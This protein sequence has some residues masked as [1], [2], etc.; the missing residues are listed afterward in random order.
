[1]IKTPFTRMNHQSWK[2]GNRE[3]K[4][5]EGKKG[6]HVRMS[7]LSDGVF[8]GNSWRYFGE[9]DATRTRRAPGRWTK[10]KAR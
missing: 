8:D 9:S 4:Q 2:S 10:K 7:R 1:M 6:K 5:P 3:E